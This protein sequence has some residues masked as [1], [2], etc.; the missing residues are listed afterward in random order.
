MSKANFYRIAAKI[1]TVYPPRRRQRSQVEGS[2]ES[3][4]TERAPEPRPT[5]HPAPQFRRNRRFW[6]RRL[7]LGKAP[8]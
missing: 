6:L 5:Y 8:R 2:D 7:G 3:R 4:Q 1:K